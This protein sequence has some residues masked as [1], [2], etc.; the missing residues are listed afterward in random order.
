[1]SNPRTPPPRARTQ[2]ATPTIDPVAV[3]VAQDEPIAPSS[4]EARKPARKRTSETA[5]AR[6]SK[7]ASERAST[8]ATKAAS[9]AASKAP[10]KTASRARKAAVVAVPAVPAVDLTAPRVRTRPR[11]VEQLNTR[12]TPEMRAAVDKHVAETGEALVDLVDRALRLAIGLE[13]E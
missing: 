11:Y 8:P 7:P 12:L 1:M 9:K 13:G 2:S 3:L 5:S 10:V 4:P 6:A